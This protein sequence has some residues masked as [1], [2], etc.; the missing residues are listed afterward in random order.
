MRIESDG[1]ASSTPGAGKMEDNDDT[2]LPPFVS[3]WGGF[4]RLVIG[5][6]IVLILVFYGI[7]K[8]FA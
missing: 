5:A 8:Y 3:T 1:D 4:Y 2:G 6:L 7:Q